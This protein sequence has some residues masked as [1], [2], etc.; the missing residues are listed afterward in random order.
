MTNPQRRALV[1]IAAR[2]SK[3]QTKWGV[4]VHPVGQTVR[5]R[6]SQASSITQPQALLKA[7]TGVLN[8]V[9]AGA[10]MEIICNDNYLSS[11]IQS[12]LDRWSINNW[13]KSDGK[14]IKNQ[15]LWIGVHKAASRHSITARR[16]NSDKEHLRLEQLKDRCVL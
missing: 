5:R 13:R 7:V 1:Y 12:D 4:E 15:E 10:E 3:G 16:S 2:T 8:G 11:G 14:P 6:I 9:S